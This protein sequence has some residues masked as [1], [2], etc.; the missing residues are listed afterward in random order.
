[1]YKNASLTTS[2]GVVDGVVDGTVDVLLHAIN[3]ERRHNV[4]DGLGIKKMFKRCENKYLSRIRFPIPGKIV[5]QILLFVKCLVLCGPPGRCAAAVLLLCCCCAAAVLLL[6][7]RCCAA[8]VF[9][10]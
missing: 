3:K 9:L 1:M 8:A 5:M 10:L 7:C 2:D 6:L 4:A